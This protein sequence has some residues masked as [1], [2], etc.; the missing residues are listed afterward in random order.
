MPQHSFDHEILIRTVAGE[1]RSEP[2]LGQ[3]AVAHVI[4]NRLAA[5][6]TL[7]IRNRWGASIAEICLKPQQ[8]SCW[9]DRDQNRR[10]IINLRPCDAVYNVAVEA[11]TN[12]YRNLLTDPTGSADH[13]HHVQITPFWAKSLQKTALIGN[14]IFYREMGASNPNVENP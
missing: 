4:L 10:Y 8:F 11:V 7:A 12:A 5:A 1:A 13:Y 6:T 3:Q 14:H 9:D 2:P